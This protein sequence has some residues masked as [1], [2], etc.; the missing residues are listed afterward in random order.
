MYGWDFHPYPPIRQENKMFFQSRCPECGSKLSGDDDPIWLV[1][2]DTAESAQVGRPC[3][4]CDVVALA[5]ERED[6]IIP[7]DHF[8]LTVDMQPRQ[9]HL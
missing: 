8:F 4:E 1:N 3:I 5:N 9:M 6:S 7:L 2:E